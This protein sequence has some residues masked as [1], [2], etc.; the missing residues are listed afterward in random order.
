MFKQYGFNSI[1]VSAATSDPAGIPADEKSF[2]DEV[3]RVYGA[4]SA[5]RL[6]DITHSEG[7][8]VAARGNLA[9]AA[10]SSAE[11]TPDSMKRFYK[12]KLAKKG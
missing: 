12:S 4:F 5:K 8:W 7:P 3:W 2:L 6:E 10:K 11:I 9:P 1:P